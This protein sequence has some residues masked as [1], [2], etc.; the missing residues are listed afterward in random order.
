MPRGRRDSPA[1]NALARFIRARM[2]DKGWSSYDVERKGGPPARTVQHLA[3]PKV[4][5]KVT[6]RPDTLKKLAAGLEVS[7]AELQEAAGKAVA[8]G[9][10]QATAPNH[11]ARVAALMADLSEQRQEQIAEFVERMIDTWR[12]EEPPALKAVADKG[13]RRDAVEVDRKA[14]AERKKQQK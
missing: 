2:E 4:Q 5:W 9:S 12:V 13:R 7:L 14:A 11:V 8:G 6:P 1:M 3:D 10:D